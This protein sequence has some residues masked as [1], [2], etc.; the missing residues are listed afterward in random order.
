MCSTAESSGRFPVIV[1]A[2]AW[3]WGDCP[4]LSCLF[5]PQAA[6]VARSLRGPEGEQ[7]PRV[8]PDCRVLEHCADE[9]ALDNLR[10]VSDGLVSDEQLK[11]VHGELLAINLGQE[12][13]PHSLAP[14]KG[15]WFRLRSAAKAVFKRFGLCL[16]H[17]GLIQDMERR[18]C[19]EPVP[20]ETVLACCLPQIESTSG[21]ALA[22]S[23]RQASTLVTSLQQQELVCMVCIVAR[24][25]GSKMVDLSDALLPRALEMQHPHCGI[26]S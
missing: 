16:R 8:S 19:L 1:S 12:T 5:S 21:T 17:I 13:R 9:M 4:S 11:Q 3:Y 25:F 7:L 10:I 15:T 2:P 14:L 22:K 26:G 24:A 18:Q 6:A 20:L 23:M